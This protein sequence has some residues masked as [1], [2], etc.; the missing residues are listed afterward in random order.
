MNGYIPDEDVS[1]ICI[2]DGRYVSVKDEDVH[3]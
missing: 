1:W 2:L 3:K